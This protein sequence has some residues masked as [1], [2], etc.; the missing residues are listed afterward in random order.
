M[1]FG[2]TKLFFP[3]GVVPTTDENLCY[4]ISFFLKSPY[5][6]V[7]VNIMF[8]HT[9]TVSPRQAGCPKITFYHDLPLAS[10]LD[11]TIIMRTK[12]EEGV[13]IFYL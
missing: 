12:G 10:L 3:G 1:L 5:C 2:N 8:P 13:I 11:N 6:I 7:F 4:F 9:R